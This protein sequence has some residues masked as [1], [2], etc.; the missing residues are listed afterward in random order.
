MSDIPRPGSGSELYLIPTI[1]VAPSTASEEYG[2]EPGFPMPAD[3]NRTNARLG[4]V[5]SL[6][7]A[8]KNQLPITITIEGIA[9]LKAGIQD[10]I[11]R[12]LSSDR[13]QITDLIRQVRRSLYPP[14]GG[15]P[16]PRFAV[17][18]G[19]GPLM[20]IDPDFSGASFSTLTAPAGYVMPANVSYAPSAPMVIDARGR[21]LCC[22][23]I[24]DS[25]GGADDGKH[26]IL[27]YYFDQAIHTDWQPAVSVSDWGTDWVLN[28]GSIL[29]TPHL[30]LVNYRN[31]V[32]AIVSDTGSISTAATGSIIVYRLA[33]NGAT[34]PPW[35]FE[36]IGDPV[37]IAT[38]TGVLAN[39]GLAAVALPDRV[40]VA[41]GAVGL[42]DYG[43]REETRGIWIGQSTDLQDWSEASDNSGGFT[44]LDDFAPVLPLESDGSRLT[45]KVNKVRMYLGGDPDRGWAVT[46]NGKIYATQDGGAS[47]SQQSSPVSVPLY[48]VACV[49]GQGDAITLYACGG[50][51]CVLKSVDSGVTWKVVSI[52]VGEGR[53]IDPD[54]FTD[55]RSEY[56]HRAPIG[57][58]PL[59]AMVWS[60]SD[61]GWIV[62]SGKIAFTEN[63]GGNWTAVEPRETT[64]TFTSVILVDDT[65]ILCGGSI[66]RQRKRST[67]LG[68]D[69]KRY[70]FVRITNAD[71]PNYFGG[72][73][74]FHDQTTSDAYRI[75][76]IYRRSATQAYACGR[77]GTLLYSSTINQSS[78]TWTA[79]P[80][81]APKGR[82][83]T[84]LIWREGKS[85]STPTEVKNEFIVATDDG[86][87]ARSVNNGASWVLQHVGSEEAGGKLA[88]LTTSTTSDDESVILYAGGSGLW[89]TDLSAIFDAFPSLT[90]LA[91][92]EILLATANLQAGRIDLRR[93]RN[94]GV[95]FE[96]VDLSDSAVVTFTPQ[97]S[98]STLDNASLRPDLAIADDG[99][100]LL[101][102]GGGGVVNL[103]GTA[104]QW[105]PRDSKQL[106][107][108]L[109]SLSITSASTQN[110]SRLTL[111]YGGGRLFTTSV[112]SSGDIQT[113]TAREWSSTSL[114]YF[115][116]VIPSVAQ[117]I[118]V[119]DIKVVW[120]SV[121]IPKGD[122]WTIEASYRYPARHLVTETRGMFWRNSALSI[123]S[124]SV[125]HLWDRQDADIATALG[126]GTVWNVTAGAM[127]GVNFRRAVLAIS[128]PSHASATWPTSATDYTEF[129]LDGMVEE[130]ILRLAPNNTSTGSPYN[131]LAVTGKTWVPSQWKPAHRRYYA[132]IDTGS[133]PVVSYPILDNGPDFLVIQRNENAFSVAAGHTVAIVG[134]RLF[135]DGTGGRR[136]GLPVEPLIDSPYEFGRLVRLVIPAQPTPDGYAKIEGLCFGRH[137]PITVKT[138]AG[139]FL[140]DG[141]DREF[142]TR[143]QQS[144]ILEKSLTGA[145]AVETF[146]SIQPTYRQSY[147]G[148]QWFDIAAT[149]HPLLPM[150]RRA[151]VIA[152][153]ASDPQRTCEW[154]RMLG[155]PEIVHSGGDLHS[156]TLELEA[157]K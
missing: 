35:E 82:N 157:V 51:G 29:N 115:C 14:T 149:M 122:S 65:T 147:S 21:L 46:D 78:P 20:G 77:G 53:A 121:N 15:A 70:R 109:G 64:A 7:E 2:L 138:A 66:Q 107:L 63:G 112:N 136:N 101:T 41:V 148:T 12:A 71:A 118:G 84:D 145:V 90:A 102:A 5:G 151:F 26:R 48:D 94:R 143:M 152:F 34:S 75:E 11:Q 13:V 106:P 93:S 125:T 6:S 62:G 129:F 87:I 79:L 133:G 56:K 8:D 123:V 120:P 28:N 95:T 22:Y 150:L 104:S 67:P 124:N 3:T 76:A 103:D 17:T 68:V 89:R 73:Y 83:F 96:R 80:D 23:L 45:Q 59:Y 40:V 105:L 36:Q 4:I 55:S 116:P 91:T 154:V 128:I 137:V 130:A 97:T 9:A 18:R 30:A 141:R 126:S 114:A 25:S 72:D 98:F 27:A 119:G 155:D 44:A 132:E 49:S 127:F 61:R 57:D 117:R 39:G 38:S 24:E 134:D 32:Y 92:G 37:R 86:L 111:P 74:S 1:T 69:L 33:T 43:F 50:S 42:Q 58:G 52:A 135:F 144:A 100:I 146:G 19:G 16:V 131:V 54:L 88:V 99:A 60:S 47:W 81:T 153:D 139:E 10:Q 142:S 108:P 31:E 140:R 110:R 113:R 156:V 85:G